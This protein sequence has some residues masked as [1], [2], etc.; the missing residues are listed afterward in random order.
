MEYR[1]RAVLEF[2]NRFGSGIPPLFFQAPA[3]INIIGEHVDY[4]GG[5]VVPAAI[6]FHIYAKIRTNS[7]Q[8]YRLYSEDLDS[9]LEVTS[10]Q[11]STTHPWA[12]Y[13]MGMVDEF[14]KKGFEIPGF[15]LSFGGNIPRGSGLSSSAALE[16]V[17]GYAINEVYQCGLSLKDIALMGQSAEHNYA[18]THCGIMDQFIIAHGKENHCI[19]LNTHTLEFDCHRM[20]LKDCELLLVQSNVKHSLQDSAYNE[21]RKQ[22]E[23]ALIKIQN[24]RKLHHLTKINNLYDLS[25]NTD[26]SCYNLSEEE[27]KRVSHVL[28]EKERTE[29]LLDCMKLGDMDEVGSVLTECHWSLANNFEVSCPETDFIVEYLSEQGCIGARMIGGGFGGCVLVLDRKGKSDLWVSKIKEV[30]R[31]KFDLELEILPVKIVGGVS[32]FYP[33]EMESQK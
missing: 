11:P 8:L 24:F 33:L 31:K 2:E 12:N 23:S 27:F 3:R 30:Y 18:N 6:D 9:Y 17:I 29:R 22:C 10:I 20:D 21:R 1:D 5:I 16:V 15:D 7:K 13:I 32:Q 14:K 19:T 28:S 4:L 26:L 25:W